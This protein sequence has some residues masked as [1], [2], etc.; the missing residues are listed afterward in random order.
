MKKQTCPC[1]EC[2]C[3]GDVYVCAD[4]KFTVVV[5]KDC[6]CADKECVSLACCGKPMTKVN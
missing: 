4:C 1:D 6:T 2:P 3:C 5:E